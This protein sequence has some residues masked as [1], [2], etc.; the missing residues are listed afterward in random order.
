MASGKT[1]GTQI[2]AAYAVVLGWCGGRA[3]DDNDL[4]VLQGGRTPAERPIGG[5]HMDG[6]GALRNMLRVG[7]RP[8]L[9]TVCE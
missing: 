3:H 4:R 5:M 9:E 7:V 6:S 8:Y 2:G 1:D